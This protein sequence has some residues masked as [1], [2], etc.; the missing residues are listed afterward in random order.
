MLP[1]GFFRK[2]LPTDG[3]E[4]SPNVAVE[5]PSS[6]TTTGFVADE[7]TEG[8]SRSMKSSSS[9]SSSKTGPGTALFRFRFPPTFPLM[10]F[11]ISLSSS[12]S[13]RSW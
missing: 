4:A 6:T 5:K 1:S 7:P 10:A 12:L 3:V 11:L 9:S 13:R 2:A 8:P